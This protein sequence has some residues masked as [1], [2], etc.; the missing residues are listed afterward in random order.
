LSDIATGLLD[1]LAQKNQSAMAL[2][3]SRMPTWAQVAFIEGIRRNMTAQKRVFLGELKKVTSQIEVV[4][5][6]GDI[7]I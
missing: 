4:D 6:L 5:E 1:N 2:T 3:L 7:K